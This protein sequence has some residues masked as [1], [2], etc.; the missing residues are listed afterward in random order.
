MQ[1]GNTPKYT[2][3]TNPQIQE[4]LQTPN[5]ITILYLTAEL[6][7]P[8]IDRK[9]TL[10]HKRKTGDL[11]RKQLVREPCSQQEQLQK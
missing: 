4:A 10:K 11:Q 5:R 3:D 9:K 7:K 8:K 1:T 2:K 6:E